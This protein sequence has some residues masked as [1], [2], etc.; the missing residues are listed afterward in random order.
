MFPDVRGRAVT[1]AAFVATIVHAA[2]L[3]GVAR[4]NLEGTLRVSGHSLRPTGA[5]GLA[6]LGL[7]AWA[8]QLLGRWGSRT[9]LDY[10]RDASTGPEAAMARRA[11]LGRNLRDFEAARESGESVADVTARALA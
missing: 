9:V 4:E 2:A 3:L 6:R 5:Q 7:D 8:I 11:V 10:V 1:K